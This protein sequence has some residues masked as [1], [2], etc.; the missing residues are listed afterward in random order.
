MLIIFFILNIY[1][2]ELS[3]N[4]HLIKKVK[5]LKDVK[6]EVDTS[7]NFR[8][9]EAFAYEQKINQMKQD[10][11]KNKKN[12]LNNLS[13]YPSH[14]IEQFNNNLLEDSSTVIKDNKLILPSGI[15][16]LHDK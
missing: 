7:M 6:I 9:A 15:R 3:I 11:G 14:I 16:K 13:I 12:I 5:D 10:M 4:E 8:D 1:N 2:N